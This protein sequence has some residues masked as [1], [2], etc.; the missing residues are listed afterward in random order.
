MAKPILSI[1]IIAFFPIFGSAEP[2]RFNRDVLPILA[3]K[4]YH[5][6]GPDRAR[7][8]ADLRPRP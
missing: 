6:H 5:C 7:R 2:V 1:V 8:K 3:D 4:C